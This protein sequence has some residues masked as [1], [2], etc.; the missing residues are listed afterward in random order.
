[1]VEKKVKVLI[2]DDEQMICDV[3]ETDLSERG[4]LCTSV[5][6]GKDALAKL[7]EEKYQV[8]LLDIVLPG[9]I[10]GIETLVEILQHHGYVAVIM[11]TGINSPDVAIATEGYG[12]SGYIV[13]PFDLNEVDASIR[14]AL[15]A[16]FGSTRL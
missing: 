10:S 1:M 4:Y 8:V 9:G 2:V 16:K 5:R 7:C 3:L 15:L 12:A 13:K 11:I 14:K 6:N